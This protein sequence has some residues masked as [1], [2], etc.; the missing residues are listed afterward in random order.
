MSKFS[1]AG[2]ICTSNASPAPTLLPHSMLPAV[3]AA[4]SRSGKDGVCNHALIRAFKRYL[5][6]TC[7]VPGDTHPQAVQREVTISTDQDQ[8][9]VKPQHG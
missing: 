4:P 6:H 1:C 2:G 7:H 8:S 5:F 3:R 9:Q